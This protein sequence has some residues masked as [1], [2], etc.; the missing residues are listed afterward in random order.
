MLCGGTPALAN[1]ATEQ[2]VRELRALQ[3]DL[4]EEASL[5][6]YACCRVGTWTLAAQRRPLTGAQAD[7]ELVFSLFRTYELVAR[8]CLRSRA[9]S[10]AADWDG[11]W[12][13]VVASSTLLRSARS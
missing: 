1:Q 6:G 8:W 4:R 5:L 11:S 7:T 9:A 10:Q 2:E 12:N 13:A 3:H